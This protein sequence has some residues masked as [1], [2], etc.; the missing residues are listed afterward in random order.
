MNPLINLLLL[1]GFFLLVFIAGEIAY[2]VFHVHAEYTRK[3][4]HIGSGFLSL[5]FPYYFDSLLWVGII[6]FLFL[7]ILVLSKP[8]KLLPSINA[9]SRQTYGSFLF[10]VAVFISFWAYI[11]YDRDLLFFYLPVLTLAICDL[12]AGLIGQ[13]FPLKKIQLFS[14]SKSVGG[15]LAFV[16]SSLCLNT[17]MLFLD[18]HLSVTAMLLIPLLVAL[19]ELVSPKGIDNISIPVSVIL[20]LQILNT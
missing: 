16:L 18:F 14:G 5:L 8:L 12:C 4:S 10:P 2:R 1:S 6:C 11:E 19:V 17:S 9:V 15:F 20:L 7:C 3:W 13:R